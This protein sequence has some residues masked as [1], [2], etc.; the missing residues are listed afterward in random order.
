[1]IWGD[2]ETFC[3]V[4]ITHGTYRYAEA[5]EVMLFAYAIDDAPAVC[6]DLTAGEPMPGDLAI[7]LADDDELVD[8]HN[9]MFD[10]TVLNRSRNLRVSIPLPRWRDTMVRALAHSLPGSL[11][12]LCTILKIPEEEAK[13][14]EGRQLLMLF[15][16]PRPKNSKLRRAT[17]ETHPEEWAR[18]KTYACHDVEGMRAVNRKLPNWNYQGE[19]LA[20]WHLDQAINDR[21][22]LVDVD[23]AQAAIRAVERAQ[24]SL[25]DRTHVLTDGEVQ[26][27]TQRDKLLKHI[28][29][30]YGVDLPDMQADTLE[31]RI[32]DPDLPLELRELIAIRLQ[33]STSSTSK[34]NS[35]VRGVN[36]D[37]RL[38]GTLQFAGALRTARWAG[39]MFQPQN[40]P[41]LDSDAVADWCE[42]EKLDKVDIT[43]YLDIGVEALKSN[44][45]DLVYD[46]VMALCSNEIRGSIVAPPGR[47]LVVSDLSNIEGRKGAWLAGERWKLQAFRDFDTIIGV[48]EKGKPVRKGPD[49]YNLA[50]AKSFAVSPDQVSTEQ[51]QIGKVQELM[52]QYEGGVGAFL[53]GAA[54]YG[55]DLDHMAKMAMPS[56]PTDVL[57]E[58]EGFLEWRLKN[59]LGN[60]GL[61]TEV[62]L[63]CESLK[64][65]WR[66]QHPEI[67][68][69]WSV[70]LA[71]AKV[72]VCNP[73]RWFKAGEHLAFRRDGAWLRMRLPSGRFLCY[74]SPL[75]DDAG[76]LSYMGINQYSRKWQRLKTYGGKLM[77]NACQAS[78]RDVMARAMPVAQDQG[79]DIVLTVHDELITE[80]DDIPDMSVELLSQILANNPRWAEGL[81][82]AA[83]GFETYRY[84]KA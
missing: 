37:N 16:K 4:P 22:V 7:A 54:T 63:A 28:L 75:I 20:L 59:R 72:A 53:T 71:Q 18:F 39:R 74:P 19:E 45:E 56:V 12:K 8:F 70:L 79:F 41:R 51:R 76:K 25:A 29:A 77:E 32:Q 33:A 64:R 50:Y 78:S 24:A 58:A 34:Y 82:L 6:W 27:A 44:A 15:C 10:R 17:R 43:R 69:L 36:L 9:A 57:E 46:N 66:R 80:A 40:L 30:E 21:G 1:M 47:K 65:L 11:D 73:G 2:L 5:C 3:E 52:L 83:G 62:F 31:R 68:D 26:K 60:F 84:R 14:K 42:V 48:D 61:P 49:L 23:L 38:R 55:I 67:V 13:Q 35:L 81:P